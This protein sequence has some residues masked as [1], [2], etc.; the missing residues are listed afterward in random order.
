MMMMMVLF[1]KKTFILIMLFTIET[2]AETFWVCE[3][4]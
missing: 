2:R 1:F 3:K 4:M